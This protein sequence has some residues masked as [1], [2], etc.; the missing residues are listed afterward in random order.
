MTVVDDMTAADSITSASMTADSMTAAG[1]TTDGQVPLIRL[2][3]GLDVMAPSERAAEHH[4]AQVAMAVRAAGALDLTTATHR[5]TVFATP[6]VSMSILMLTGLTPGRLLEMLADLL[7][8]EDGAQGSVALGD[9]RVGL[10]ALQV[11][12]SAAAAAHRDRTSGRA[13][14]F[15]GSESLTGTV[16]LRQ[17]LATT[18]DRI[19]ALG[20]DSPGADALLVT[21]DFVRPRWQGGELVLHVQPAIGG[22]WVPFETPN[23]TPCCAAHR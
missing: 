2:V 4:L 19:D 22:T 21:R 23:P 10:P 17:V 20:G 12:A 3:A 9:S 5:A 11:S 16:A 7:A 8:V 18:I 15:P 14:Q 1:P 6:H 13:V